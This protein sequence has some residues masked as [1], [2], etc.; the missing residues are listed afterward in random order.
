MLYLLQIDLGDNA[1]PIL[2]TAYVVH[3]IILY[4]IIKSA[5]VSSIQ[6]MHQSQIRELRKSNYLK[7]LDLRQR[8]VD[9]NEIR[10]IMQE[11]NTLET[12]DRDLFKGNIDHSEYQEKRKTLVLE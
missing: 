12:I 1:L 7:L 11:M 6:K 4:L 5:V 9:D 3:A 10:Q 8:G 2:V